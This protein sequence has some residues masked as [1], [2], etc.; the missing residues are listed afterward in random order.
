MD[1]SFFC[2]LLFTRN[3][4]MQPRLLCLSCMCQKKC[5]NPQ[6]GQKVENNNN[7]NNCKNKRRGGGGNLPH[8]ASGSQTVNQSTHRVRIVHFLVIIV[9]SPFDGN[10]SGALNDIAMM[11]SDTRA[12]EEEGNIEN[13]S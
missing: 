4:D 5:D 7:N 2:P 1:T 11:G 10:S 9:L 3:R 13:N 8:T 6:A 12:S